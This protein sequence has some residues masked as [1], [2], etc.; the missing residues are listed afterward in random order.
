MEW[1]QSQRA[2]A[3]WGIDAQKLDCYQ[4]FPAYI[5]CL[6]PCFTEHHGDSLETAPDWHTQ[7]SSSLQDHMVPLSRVPV[8]QQARP[9]SRFKQSFGPFKQKP[10]VPNKW[11]AGTHQ[12]LLWV[13]YP[14]RSQKKAQYVATDSNQPNRKRIK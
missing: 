1:P 5:C 10:P 3:A 4:V 13:G 9:Q 2:S 11:Y 12:V 14:V 6:G 8:W 7:L